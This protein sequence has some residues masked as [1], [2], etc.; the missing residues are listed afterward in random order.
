MPRL[1]PNLPEHCL[2]LPPSLELGELLVDKVTGER[3]AQP[4]IKYSLRSLITFRNREESGSKTIETARP[5][6]I[7]PYT[8]EFPPTETEDFPAEFKEQDSKVL[9]RHLMAGALGELTV[10]VREPPALRYEAQALQART[11]ASAKLEFNSQSSIQMYQILQGLSFTVFSLVRI[12]TFYSLQTFPR[13]PSQS[14]LSVHG[15]TRMR[16]EMIK[17]ETRTL[18]DVSWRYTYESGNQTQGNLF[19]RTT[20]YF[21]SLGNQ[22]NELSIQAGSKLSASPAQGKWTATLG[23]PI[24]SDTRL[25]PTFC[26]SVVARLYTLIVRVKVG[27]VRTESF[28]LE[29]PLQVI[30]SFPKGHPSAYG[31]NFEQEAPFEQFRRVSESSWLSEESLVYCF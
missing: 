6:I 22:A 28:D 16:D 30:H 15:T 7:A 17:L 11:S 4:S 14:L 25:L 10:S 1:K 27:G 24:K 13:L 3:F 8:E 20:S 26:T 5:V 19:P 31:E 2:Q 21:C 9:R 12:K 18:R 23:I 29:V